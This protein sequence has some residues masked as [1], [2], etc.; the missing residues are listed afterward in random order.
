[1]LGDRPAQSLGVDGRGIDQALQSDSAQLREDGDRG[2]L[3]GDVG[4]DGAV[5]DPGGDVRAQVGAERLVPFAEDPGQV[6]RRGRLG[7]NI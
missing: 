5:G 1:V 3:G 4:P 7:P 6:G 2:L